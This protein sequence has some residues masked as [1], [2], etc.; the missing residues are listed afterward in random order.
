MKPFFLSDFVF[1]IS[2][3]RNHGANSKVLEK[4]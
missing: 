3:R 4:D 2:D 1:E